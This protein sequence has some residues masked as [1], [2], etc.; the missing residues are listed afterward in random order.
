[1]LILLLPPPEYKFHEGKNNKYLV[2]DTVHSAGLWWWIISQDIIY[3]IF[4]WMTYWNQIFPARDD[5]LWLNMLLL[6]TQLILG[7][8]SGIIYFS[9][10]WKCFGETRCEEGKEERGCRL[11]VKNMWGNQTVQE[12]ER[13]WPGKIW[14]VNFLNLNKASGKCRKQEIGFLKKRPWE[15]QGGYH[16]L[17][18]G[19]SF[20]PNSSAKVNCLKYP[21]S[22]Q[23]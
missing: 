9:F 10:C 5:F 6:F 16:I 14:R 17:H 2:Y 22:W 19:T 12:E 1:M 15:R 20:I 23:C 21:E 4:C 11:G 8:V 13:V 3:H 7:I 18:A